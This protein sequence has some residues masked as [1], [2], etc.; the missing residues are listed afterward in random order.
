MSAQPSVD[1][2]PTTELESRAAT[3]GWDSVIAALI[4]LAEDSPRVRAI[5]DEV[6]ERAERVAAD[7]RGLMA[8]QPYEPEDLMAGEY[9]DPE[10]YLAREGVHD[11]YSPDDEV[12]ADYTA[13]EVSPGMWEITTGPSFLTFYEPPWRISGARDDQAFQDYCRAAHSAI[14]RRARVTWN[15]RR[16]NS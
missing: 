3:V 7:S 14:Q 16:E 12:L 2:S 13:D 4:T 11:N 8:A 9:D 15:L 10:Q 6:V 1:I 5:F